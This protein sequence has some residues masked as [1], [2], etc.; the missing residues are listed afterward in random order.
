MPGDLVGAV[1]AG[2][3]STRMDGKPK[4]LLQLPDGRM[5]IDHVIDALRGV[6][7]EVILL[8]DTAARRDLD[9]VADLREAVG[10]LGGIEAML[11][12]GR[13]ASYLV[14]PC[15][16]PLVT[17]ELLSRLVVDSQAAVFTTGSLPLFVRA[18]SAAIA[19]AQLDKDQRAVHRFVQCL[20]H[21]VIDVEPSLLQ[22]VNTPDDLESLLRGLPE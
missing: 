15:D 8:G 11:R 12:S 4:E 13:G 17:T 22:N 7:S 20:D 3:R 18:S 14:C 21:D 10:P 6:C 9:H 16:V 19:T 5:M 1:L 2:G